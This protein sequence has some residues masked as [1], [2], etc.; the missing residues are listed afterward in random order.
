MAQPPRT[1]VIQGTTPAGAACA[2]LLNR[3]GVSVRMAP[4]SGTVPSSLAV[5]SRALLGDL[6]LSGSSLSQPVE[7]IIDRRLTED[8]G[9]DSVKN[10]ADVAIVQRSELVEEL[11]D[12]IDVS[13]V[14][15]SDHPTLTVETREFRLGDSEIQDP[16]CLPLA[17]VSECISLDWELGN[18]AG[19]TWI[20]L[21]GEGLSDVNGRASILT[22]PNRAA[23][24][25]L[26]PMA[27]IIETSISVV[28]VL[29]R[30]LTHPAVSSTIPE[31][32]PV[33]TGTRLLRSGDPL[34]LTVRGG[35]T[36]RVGAAAGLAD[37][38]L[39]DRELR[40][41]MVAAE[42]I[43]A[44]ISEARTNV[45]RLSR[46]GRAWSHSEAAHATHI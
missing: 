45:A 14:D 36:V 2:S 1:V 15:G 34:H 8:G 40:S 18:A 28:D 44:A 35:L 27:S 42:Q 12:G 32:V 26:L 24:I 3:A 5:V 6:G 9:L 23:L 46:I 16:E 7:R 13:A 21:N 20:R 37:P 10:L 19:A 17:K 41:G 38:V 43:A 31:V 29:A 25:L 11:M 33:L 39:L 22:T 4:S 30:L